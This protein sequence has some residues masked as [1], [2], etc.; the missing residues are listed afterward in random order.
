MDKE[1]IDR[2]WACLP[3][4]FKQEVK[5]QYRDGFNDDRKAIGILFGIDNLLSDAEGEEDEMLHVSRK[6]LQYF[7]EKL[8]AV[9]EHHAAFALQSLFGSKCLP[10]SDLN[11]RSKE[12]IV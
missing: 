9:G 1:L 12:N 11:T 3:K 10:D 4:E 2:A 8:R 5:N 7:Y 6:K